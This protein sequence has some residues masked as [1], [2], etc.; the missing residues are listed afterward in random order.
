MT[1]DIASEIEALAALRRIMKRIDSD[2]NV[3]MNFPETLSSTACIVYL[4]T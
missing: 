4:S 3:V 2:N 1:D